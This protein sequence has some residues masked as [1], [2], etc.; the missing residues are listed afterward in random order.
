MKGSKSWEINGGLFKL[1]VDEALSVIFE[2]QILGT[3]QKFCQK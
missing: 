3:V 1:H 2:Q